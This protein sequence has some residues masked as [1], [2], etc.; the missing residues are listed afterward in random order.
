[1]LRFAALFLS[2]L[3]ADSF[4]PIR[5]SNT[6]S[7]AALP[8]PFTLLIWNIDRG[9]QLQNIELGIHKHHPDIC[10]LQEVD[11]D[12]KRSEGVDEANSL[13]RE[14]NMNY[15]YGTAWRELKQGSGAWQGQ[16]NLSTIPLT[17]SRVVRF[18]HQTDF[19]EPHW[20]LPEWAPQRRHG[21]RIA[22]IS[23]IGALAFYNL[24]LE[25]R[26][27]PNR[28]GQLQEVLADADRSYPHRPVIIG[29]DLNT[30]TSVEEFVGTLEKHGFHSCFGSR[31]E[32]THRLAGDLDWI[33]VRAPAFCE[34]AAVDRDAA[35]SDHYLLTAHILV[36]TPSE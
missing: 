5:T 10:L 29:G 2:A 27:L 15:A 12:A 17:S 32:R 6:L 11:L 25:S 13:A 8:N 7:H 23:E 34:D 4:G 31:H 30:M 26:S 24:H 14:L 20:Y 35:G 36:K 19:W 21:G 16:A 9:T 22:L 3:V 18:E 1:M 28:F 33:F